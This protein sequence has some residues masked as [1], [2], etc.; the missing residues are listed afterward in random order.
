LQVEH[1]VPQA[2]SGTNRV[3][4][5]TLACA[6]CTTAKGTQTADEFGHPEVQ[7]QAR[8]PLNDA[9]AVNASRWALYRNGPESPCF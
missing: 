7:A 9:A 4:N 1:I 3:R 6:C 2:R 5:L 8:R